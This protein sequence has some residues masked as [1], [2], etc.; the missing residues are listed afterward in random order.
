MQY[1]PS[2][3]KTSQAALVY[4][5]LKACQEKCQQTTIGIIHK[6][7]VHSTFLSPWVFFCC[8]CCCLSAFVS[9]FLSEYS[10]H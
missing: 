8:C 10:V 5:S 4:G 1:G 2:E 6:N 7:T 3:E 9:L